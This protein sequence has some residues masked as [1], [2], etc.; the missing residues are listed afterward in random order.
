M[1]TQGEKLGT[2]R[3][4]QVFPVCSGESLLPSGIDPGGVL[5]SPFPTDIEYKGELLPGIEW[6]TS[7][8][9]GIW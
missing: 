4:P 7:L 3:W 2:A 6:I 1:R 5:T 9:K 8:N